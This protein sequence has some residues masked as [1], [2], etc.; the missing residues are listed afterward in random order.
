MK[1][2]FVKNLSNKKLFTLSLLALSLTTALVGCGSS[3]DSNSSSDSNQTKIVVGAT[4]LPHAE[5]LNEAIPMLKDA[6]ITLEVVEFSDYVVINPSLSS[7]ELD[8]NFFQ[9]TAYLDDYNSNSSDTLTSVGGIHIEPIALYSNSIS[10]LSD[11]SEG[12][13][14]AIPNDATNGPRALELLASNGL[15]G[16]D[17]SATSPTIFDIIDNSKNIEIIDMDAATLPRTLGDVTAAVINTNFAL[18]ADLNPIDDAIIMEGSD[19]IYANVLVVREEDK[20]KEEILELYKILTSSEIAEFIEE[21]Y[22]GAVVP[23]N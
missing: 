21:E 17:P 20:N 22:N 6:G 11:L 15:F 7:G 14:I 12:D 16:L 1:K 19:S 8:A 4:A 10:N 18:E 5:I 13:V 9:H 23:V 3:D 2:L